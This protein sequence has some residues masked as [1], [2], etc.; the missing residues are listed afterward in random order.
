MR[1]ETIY[2]ATNSLTFHK[3]IRVELGRYV[4]VV[5]YVPTNR[6]VGLS[7]CLTII[8]I[9]FGVLL[10][11]ASSAIIQVGIVGVSYSFWT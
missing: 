5:L 6:S 8:N 10:S 3:T 4:V 1:L 7:V 11:S 9:S 2:I